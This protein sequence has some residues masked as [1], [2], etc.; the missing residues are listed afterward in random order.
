MLITVVCETLTV[1]SMPRIRKTGQCLEVFVMYYS[2]TSSRKIKKPVNVWSVNVS[3]TT[4][5]FEMEFEPVI[6]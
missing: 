3:H 1:F 5:V 6:A 4:V 2:K